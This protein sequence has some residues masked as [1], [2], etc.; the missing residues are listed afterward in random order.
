MLP[1]KNNWV[2]VGIE[3][4]IRETLDKIKHT[5][6]AKAKSEHEKREHDEMAKKYNSK[7]AFHESTKKPKSESLKETAMK[8]IMA[9]GKEL[10]EKSK[11]KS[12][13]ESKKSKSKSKKNK[14]KKLKPESKEPTPD[15]SNNFDFGFGNQSNEQFGFGMFTPQKQGKKPREE[16]VDWSRVFNFRMDSDS[17]RRKYN[18][19]G[20]YDF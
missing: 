16:D 12:I 10:A 8:K 6:I 14:T 9:K 1:T 3:M 20:S 5:R 2:E 4:N 11:Q 7:K 19:Y 17:K 18:P 13:E 15:S